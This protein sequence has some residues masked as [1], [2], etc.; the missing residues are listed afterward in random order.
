MNRRMQNPMQFYICDYKGKIKEIMA[1]HNGS[2]FWDV[3][4][5]IIIN[6]L[7]L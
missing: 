7:Q 6:Y 2:E 4:S 3:S 1:R 5:M